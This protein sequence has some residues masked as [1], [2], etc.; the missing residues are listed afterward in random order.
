MGKESKQKCKKLDKR[1][2]LDGE[3]VQYYR[4]ISQQLKQD[5]D[6]QDDKGWP[7][8][9]RKRCHLM[10]YHTRDVF[11]PVDWWIFFHFK[12]LG[13]IF[14]ENSRT[15]TGGFRYFPWKFSRQVMTV[16]AIFREN[17]NATTAIVHEY[18][19]QD[20]RQLPVLFQATIFTCCQE[21]CKWCLRVLSNLCYANVI[22]C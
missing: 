9:S 8:C 6:D 5:F 2:A 19:R 17:F 20:A 21:V 1:D 15:V 14:R 13:A 11:F 22:I 3:T 18:S 16:F 12:T 10:L 7:R 4:R